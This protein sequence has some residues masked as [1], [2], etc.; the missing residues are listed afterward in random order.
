MFLK[1]NI[2]Q[3]L[4]YALYCFYRL[5]K[6]NTVSVLCYHEISS[7]N[8]SETSII[9]SVFE[10]HII[11][12]KKNG[13]KFVT[14]DAIVK[15][16]KAGK[17]DLAQSIIAITF[18]DG[19]IDNF[20]NMF[21]IITKYKIPVTVFINGYNI[22]K[23][24]FLGKNEISDM[25]ESKLVS[26]EYHGLT[27]KM[28][29]ACSDYELSIELDNSTIGYNYFAYPGGH[30]NKKIIY[31]VKAFGYYAAFS[32]APDLITVKS[33]LYDIPR[34]VVTRDMKQWEVLM[35][36]SVSQKIYRKIVR[37]IKYYV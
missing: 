27:H 25:R 18:D 4:K 5:N 14:L 12:L 20:T 31:Q 26:F 2:K 7:V 8:N 29:D 34:S 17:K 16:I 37:L 30:R 32:I 11:R 35:R 28:L 13:K 15:Y 6:T 33:N 21:P 23:K 19:Y 10:E 24:G 9:P 1:N 3:L 36:T 22:N